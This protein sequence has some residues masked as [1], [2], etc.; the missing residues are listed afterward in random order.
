MKTMNVIILS[1]DALFDANLL[2]KLPVNMIWAIGAI[3]AMSFLGSSKVS[4]S[5]MKAIEPFWK[6]VSMD[7]ATIWE[8]FNLGYIK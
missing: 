7:T 2:L 6:A 1:N 8:R 5:R 3:V 4:C